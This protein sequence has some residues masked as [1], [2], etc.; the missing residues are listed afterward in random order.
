MGGGGGGGGVHAQE[1]GGSGSIS[2]MVVE[3][4]L[5]LEHACGIQ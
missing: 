3:L 2:T 1:V 5:P 4:V